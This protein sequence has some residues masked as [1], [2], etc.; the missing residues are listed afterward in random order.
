MLVGDT[1]LNKQQAQTIYQADTSSASLNRWRTHAATHGLSGDILFVRGADS[2]TFDINIGSSYSDRG[3]RDDIHDA[4]GVVLKIP[5]HQA[6][7]NRVPKTRQ[8][9]ALKT[10]KNPAAPAL[11]QQSSSVAQ[12]A[13]VAPPKSSC[14]IS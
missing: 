8:N 14:N 5:V 3:V 9:D 7:A 4:F 13:D 10:A 11:Q 12:P 6:H 2:D 1:N